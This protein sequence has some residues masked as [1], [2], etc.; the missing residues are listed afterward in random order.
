[1]IWRHQA[2]SHRGHA[3]GSQIAIYQAQT[4]GGPSAAS[5]LVVSYVR[6][7]CL[8]HSTRWGHNDQQLD[9]ERLIDGLLE[10]GI[11][12]IKSGE[13]ARNGSHEAITA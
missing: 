11:Q 2:P 10:P 6:H 13:A 1:M 12:T 3:Q 5:S 7:P 4:A 9:S 8:L